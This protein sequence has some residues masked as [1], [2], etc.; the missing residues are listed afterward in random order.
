M[1]ILVV[2][3]STLMRTIIRRSLSS[4]DS[5]ELEVLEAEDGVQAIATFAEHGKSIDLI[6]CDMNMPNGNGLTLLRSLQAMDSFE[7]TA[8]V[9][10]T[11]DLGDSRTDDALREG[12]AAVLGK[13]FRPEEIAELVRNN[14]TASG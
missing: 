14:V 6:L 12:A 3:D 9:L 10:V 4:I 11:A 1:K 7:G 13:P 5:V 2:D 8:F